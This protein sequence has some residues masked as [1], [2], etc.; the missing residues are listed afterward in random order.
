MDAL[1]LQGNKIIIQMIM[2]IIMTMVM[3][4]MMINR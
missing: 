2:I 1:V 3:T 4:M